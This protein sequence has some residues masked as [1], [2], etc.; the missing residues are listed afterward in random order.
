MMAR[1]PQHDFDSATSCR[2]RRRDPTATSA[3][4][5]QESNRHL[6]P[7]DD[8][9]TSSLRRRGG[10]TRSRES[11]RQPVVRRTRDR[12]R[13][14]TEGVITEFPVTVERASRTW[15]GT[16]WDITTG[17]D[18]NSGSPTCGSTKSVASRRADDPRR[19]PSPAPCCLWKES[20]PAPTGT[21]WFTDGVS[22][23]IP[24]GGWQPNR[25]DHARRRGDHVPGPH[26][27]SLPGAI[28]AG[29]DGNL[30][31]VEQFA[32][33]S[34]GSPPPSWSPSSPVP[35]SPRN[36][37]PSRTPLGITVGPDGKMW[38]STVG[39]FATVGHFQP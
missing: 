30:W 7:T 18:G 1:A 35:P 10:L 6:S 3:T 15:V 32:G 21:S 20:P 19:S 11:G 12:R 34:A 33:R 39:S 25:P 36:S 31:F 9:S 24:P 14:T 4:P 23:A 13:I 27:N 22:R 26:A 8:R 5:D 37:S 2:W 16:P 38:F 28:T 29:P 17:P